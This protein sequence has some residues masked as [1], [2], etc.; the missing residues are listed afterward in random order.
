VHGYDPAKVK[1]ENRDLPSMHDL[2]HDYILHHGG[3]K[4]PKSLQEDQKLLKN[5]I[6]PSFENEQ[7]AH[8]SR[9]DIEALHREHKKIPYQ[10]NRFLA[11][12]SKMFAL[13]N[14]WGWREDNLTKGI[15]RYPEEKRNRWLT[16]EELKILWKVLDEYSNQ[17][18][19]CIFKLLILTGARKGELLYATLN[20]F[21][22]YFSIISSTSPRSF[23]LSSKI[24]QYFL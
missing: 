8:I 7:V 17:S 6:L 12:L 23:S 21:A 24:H 13:A 20:Q 5:I 1:R 4:R 16:E 11:L 18:A 19:S 9:R 3:R 22:S 2:A 14:G 15:E 10:A